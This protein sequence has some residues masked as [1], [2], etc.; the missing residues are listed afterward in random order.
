[1]TSPLITVLVTTYNYGQFIEQ[2]V[3]SILS[4][5]S[6]LEGVEILII[7][8]GSTDDTGERVKK[9]G[10]RIE[11]F[12]KPN[13]GQASALNCGI[14]K[15]R[16]DIIALMDADD[17]F[18]PGKLAR[19]ANVFEQDP[20]LGM[21][22]HRLQEWRVESDERRDWP[23]HSVSGE[24]QKS[25]GEFFWYVPQPTSAISFRKSSLKPLLP[26][27]EKI[28]MLA[29][30]YLAFLIPLVA[31]VLAIPEALTVYRIHGKNCYT[32]VEERI[33]P[34]SRR[35]KWQMWAVLF[36]EM[37]DWLANSGY[38]RQQTAV[39]DLLDRWTLYLQ[40][41]QF[42]LDPPG[43]VLFFRHLMLYNRCY[44]PHISRRLLVLNYLN[45]V[46]AIFTGY[47]HFHLLEGSRAKAFSM[48]RQIAGR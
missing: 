34:E 48:M 12:Y 28:R 18:L 31:P 32:G 22:Y 6:P 43:R 9:Y 24:M 15:A 16:G 8:D 17:I 10:S 11:Y 35:R 46:G 23:F 3:E 26:I 33:A 2:A 45:A 21:V 40:S 36:D 5:N 25:P 27:P 37:R 19:I 29:D 39:R 20:K 47:K 4:Q 38:T 41:D 42:K 44:G 1:M 13:G 30:C 14:E 7:D